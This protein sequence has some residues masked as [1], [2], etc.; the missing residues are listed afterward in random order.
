MLTYTWNLNETDRI[1][2]LKS[3]DRSIYIIRLSMPC[4]LIYKNNIISPYIDRKK[5]AI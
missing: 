5:T 1:E 4:R 2:R 3:V